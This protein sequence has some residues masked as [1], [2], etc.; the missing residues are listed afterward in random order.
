MTRKDWAVAGLCALALAGGLAIG[1]SPAHAVSAAAIDADRE[2]VARGLEAQYAAVLI[3]ER[4]LAD[5]RETRLLGAAE[6]RLTKARGELSAV[7]RDSAAELSAARADYARLATEIVQKDAASQTEIEAYRAE[8][9]Q[10]VAQATPEELAA[11]QQFADGDRVVAE[12]VLMSIREARKRATLK[13]AE[14]RIAQDE[15]ATADEHDIMREHG[16]ATTLE[17]LNLYDIAAADDPTDCKTNLMRGWLSQQEH[18]YAKAATAY[19]QAIDGARGDREREAAYRGLG[20]V[21]HM[22]ASFAEAEKTLQLALGLSLKLAAAE[23]KSVAAANDL[24]DCYIQIGLVRRAQ[25]DR[26]G[27]LAS[28]R[29]ALGAASRADGGAIDVLYRLAD[30]NEKIGDLQFEGGETTAALESH[31][32]ELA[33]ARGATGLDPKAAT[34]RRYIGRALDR[35][36]DAQEVLGDHKAALASYLEHNTVFHKLA[37]EDPTSVYYQQELAAGLGRLGGVRYHDDHDLAGARQSY[38]EQLDLNKALAAQHPESTSLQIGVA[39][40][41]GNLG[42]VQ[43]DMGDTA[44]ALDS[45]RQSLA[46]AR[47]LVG[48]DPN[49]VD[50]QSV[51]GAALQN[52]ANIPGSGV[53][54]AQAVA[55]YQEMKDRGQLRADM[56]ADLAEAKRRAAEEAKAKK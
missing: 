31:K 21:Q 52:L 42:N 43:S 36:G 41:Y 9:E 5:D 53:T 44:A 34:A 14:M 28:F 49:A 18:D 13:A 19:Q 24:A 46:T 25:G 2:T 7:K 27:A 33:I 6:A 47:G 1:G 40:G 38:T 32:Q 54:W 39:I 15:R 51:I 10:R 48:K 22:Q 16:E 20:T 11:L 56:D 17:V 3:K 55:Q 26:A 8:A 4:K 50:A 23:P 29:S 45:L 30:A 35:I 37:A 12:P